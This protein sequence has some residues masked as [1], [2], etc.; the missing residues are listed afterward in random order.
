MRERFNSSEHP[1]D[2]ALLQERRRADVSL[3]LRARRSHDGGAG[4][5]IPGGATSAH[6]A[7]RHAA[8]ASASNGRYSVMAHDAG[9]AT[10]AGARST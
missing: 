10:A 9:S 1:G 6:A 3:A 5:A 4:G 2:G 8:G 7:R